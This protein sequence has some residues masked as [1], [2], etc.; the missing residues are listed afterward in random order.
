MARQSTFSEV[1]AA[2]IVERIST[3]ET[4][5]AICRSDG[6]PAWRTV[7]DWIDNNATFAA[8]IARA[9]VLGHD[10]IAEETVDILDKE[11]ERGKDGK[12]DP[13]YVQ[14]QKNRAYQRMQL[15]AKWS[16]KKYGDRIEIDAKVDIGVAERL[17]RARK[18]TTTPDED[19]GSD[20]AG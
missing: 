5:R 18:R 3:G 2:E 10:A 4:L 14:W 9:R 16:P 20:L 12:I 17:A 6:M 11:P 7:Y 13:G 15:L 19:D 1:V 8:A